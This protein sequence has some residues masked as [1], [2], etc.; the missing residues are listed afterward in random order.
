MTIETNKN[1]EKSDI[2]ASNKSQYDGFLFL[3]SYMESYQAFVKSG[4]KELADLLLMS[5]VVYG[6]TGEIYTDHPIVEAV[7]ASIRRTIDNGREK[8]KKSLI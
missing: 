3:P 1:M 6:T 7:M 4:D 2:A 5:I 8:R